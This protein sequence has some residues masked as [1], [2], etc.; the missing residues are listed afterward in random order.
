MTPTLHTVPQ[1]RGESGA[2]R[3]TLFDASFARTGDGRLSTISIPRTSWKRWLLD[4]I[5]AKAAARHKRAGLRHKAVC[6]ECEH[7][8]TVTHAERQKIEFWLRR[9]EM[10]VIVPPF[11]VRVEAIAVECS[12]CGA[13]NVVQRDFIRRLQD[14][15]T[16]IL[17]TLA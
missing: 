12:A 4:E 3:L 5:E 1:M 13:S 9:S 17:S 15:Q 11:R 10:P 14:A 7:A 16:K 6:R 8:L 2:V